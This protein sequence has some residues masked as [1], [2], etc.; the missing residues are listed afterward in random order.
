M[1]NILREVESK[2]K[3]FDN[4]LTSYDKTHKLLTICTQSPPVRLNEGRTKTMIAI[5]LIGTGYTIEVYQ[6]SRKGIAHPFILES[7]R[8]PNKDVL[9]AMVNNFYKK[10]INGEYT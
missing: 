5:K 4:V 8:V 10:V 3:V 1:T 9:P 6:Q 7:V 2:Y